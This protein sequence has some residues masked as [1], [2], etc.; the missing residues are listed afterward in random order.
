MSE[1]EVI[2]F[3]CVCFEREAEAGKKKPATAISKAASPAFDH[4]KEDVDKPAARKFAGAL[5]RLLFGT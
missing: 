2:N 4:E 5:E 1:P 3:R